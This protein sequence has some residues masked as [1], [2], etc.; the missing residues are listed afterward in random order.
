MSHNP[1]QCATGTHMTAVMIT[2][3]ESFMGREI[4]FI[5]Y[6]Y[7]SIPIPMCP[8]IVFCSQQRVHHM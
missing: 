4:A 8:R 6:W 7:S 5:P 1:R 3:T 2:A